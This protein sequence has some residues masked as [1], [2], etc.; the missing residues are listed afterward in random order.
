VGV[1]V[2]AIGPLNQ[3]IHVWAYKDAAERDRLRAEAAKT[4]AGWPPETR[5]FMVK[6]ENSLMVPAGCSP[7]H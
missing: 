1:W 3:F 4:I 6:Q 5:Q 2:S 7:L